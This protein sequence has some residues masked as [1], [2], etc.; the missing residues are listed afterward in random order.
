MR[1][2]TDCSISATQRRNMLGPAGGLRECSA[3]PDK[4]HDDPEAAGRRGASNQQRVLM[5][6]LQ[7]MPTPQ[8]S[9]IPSAR[10]AAGFVFCKVAIAAHG[11]GQGKNL[12]TLQIVRNHAVDHVMGGVP[13][14][15]AA[16]LTALVTLGL[17]GMPANASSPGAWNAY[18]QEV[19]QACIAASGL[20]NARPAG[21]R[22]DLSDPGGGSLISV[23]LLEG[24]APQPHMNS[25]REVELCVYE[26]SSR[27]ARVADADR[28]TTR[29]P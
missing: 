27:Q 1:R 5:C 23:L 11:T 16:G 25:S 29:K 19:Q 4:S 21:E 24:T 8:A 3:F 2:H 14:G 12:P 13:I 26:A 15:C 10:A 20:R 17:G 7:A 18:G 22:L 6:Q 28:L 9:L